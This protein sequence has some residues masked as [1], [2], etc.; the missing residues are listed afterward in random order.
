MRELLLEACAFNWASISPAIFG[1]LF[2]AVKS[3]EARRELGEHYTTET[4]ILKTIEP[5]FLDELRQQYRD[6]VHEVRKLKALREHLGQLR[7]LDPAC[8]CGNFLVVA[9]RELRRLDL[10]ILKRLQDLGDTSQIP[11]LYFTKDDLP[12]RLEHFTGIEIE[13]WPARIAATALHLADH[14]ANQELELSL[15]KAPDPLPP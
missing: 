8:G 2:Q 14:Q 9:Y 4:N 5:L 10:E 11:M 15:G 12:V 6:G 3:A 1:S 7:F 13:E